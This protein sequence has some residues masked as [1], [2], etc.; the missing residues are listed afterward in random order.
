MSQTPA[1]PDWSS[2]HSRDHWKKKKKKK[3]EN[4]LD[5]TQRER[6]I[7]IVSC[8]F[9]SSAPSR[10]PASFKFWILK[11]DGQKTMF[12]AAELKDFCPRE[13]TQRLQF[14]QLP[15][16]DPSLISIWPKKNSLWLRKG[17]AHFHECG[18]VWEN[19]MS[20]SNGPVTSPKWREVGRWWQTGAAVCVCVCV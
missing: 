12:W 18:N 14:S 3:S 8:E 9:Y 20:G 1:F 17:F 7:S 2:Q 16:P 11:R 15:N 4:L 6:M 19:L 10:W 13:S 5:Q